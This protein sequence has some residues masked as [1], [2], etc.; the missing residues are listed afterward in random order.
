MVHKLKY[1]IH[2]CE[3]M[4]RETIQL[5]FQKLI[6]KFNYVILMNLGL[7]HSCVRDTN[8]IQGLRSHWNCYFPYRFITSEREV[9]KQ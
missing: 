7:L 5:L 3:Y 1:F 8:V 6:F 2:S 4:N 9:E